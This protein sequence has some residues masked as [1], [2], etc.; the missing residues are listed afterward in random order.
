[1]N[2]R[3]KKLYALLLAAILSVACI[4]CEQKTERKENTRAGAIDVET[5]SDGS[6][7]TEEPVEASELWE[8]DEVSE[9]VE[10]IN[11]LIDNY[12]YFDVDR[13][14]Q[15]EAL[16]DGIMAGLDDPYSVY[17][18]K[19]EYEDMMEES[20]GE[21][22]GIGAVVTKNEDMHVEVVRP[23]KNSPAMEAGLQAGDII[24]QVDDMEI[25]DLELTVVVDEIRG[26]EGTN[27]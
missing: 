7:T 26:E 23:I 14:K 13:E 2:K 25:T 19:E 8:D 11:E 1:M 5:E 6:Q 15:E 27:S 16:Y 22:V 17:Y 3:A 10:E 21:Y 9:K 4:G 20:S 24:V 18:T 12:Y